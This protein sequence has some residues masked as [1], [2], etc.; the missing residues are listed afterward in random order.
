[1]LWVKESVEEEEE[2][3]LIKLFVDFVDIFEVS[4]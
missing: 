2:L 4:K 1:M 3:Y